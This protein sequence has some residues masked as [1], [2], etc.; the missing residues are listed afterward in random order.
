M[1]IRMDKERV[2]EDFC[3]NSIAILVLFVSMR[4]IVREEPRCFIVNIY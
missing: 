3:I 1:D 2:R 4:I